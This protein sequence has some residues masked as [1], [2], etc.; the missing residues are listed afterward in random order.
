MASEHGSAAQRT[1][2]TDPTNGKNWRSSR[3]SGATC[4]TPST[5]ATGSWSATPGRDAGTGPRWTS[6]HSTS[7]RSPR[8]TRV[9]SEPAS[10][11]F[12]VYPTIAEALRCG[13]TKLAVDGVLIIGE[14]GDYPRNDKGQILY[15]A[16]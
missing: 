16:V 13:G 7:I 10:F 1:T 14:H 5:W 4:R 15:P 11:G 6:S 9:P 2:I 3:P 8:T 12:K